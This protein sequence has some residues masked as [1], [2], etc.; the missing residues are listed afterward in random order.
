MS[1]EIEMLLIPVSL[2]LI[3]NNDITPPSPPIQIFLEDTFNLCQV[4][5]NSAPSVL[6]KLHLG[7]SKTQST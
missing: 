5:E 7:L 6:T 3:E 2:T 4:L 1:W